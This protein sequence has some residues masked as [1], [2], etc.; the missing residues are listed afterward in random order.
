MA[1]MTSTASA[2]LWKVLSSTVVDCRSA[3]WATTRCSVR[4]ATA[5]SSFS[6]AARSS[7]P[8]RRVSPI[9]SIASTR[10]STTPA[11]SI[12]SSQRPLV[13]YRALRSARRLR[14]SAVSRSIL[15]PTFS[16][17]A[18]PS[19]R[20]INVS[21][22]ALSPALRNLINSPSAAMPA[23]TS[24]LVSSTNCVSPELSLTAAI[25]SSNAESK[26][27]L[28]LRYSSTKPASPVSAK[29]RAALSAPRN[30]GRKSEIL[31]RTVS[32]R[33]TDPVSLRDLTSRPIEA[34]LMMRRIA[35]PIPR[36]TRWEGIED[37]FC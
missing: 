13:L 7:R 6:L 17:A 3:S 9:R 4:S 36:V 5:A 2:M 8:E 14:S 28:V 34:A 12:A 27:A 10:I 29:P 21:I 24:A 20:A 1:S 37:L 26:A 16:I 32:V 18:R 30:R 35:K 22:P 25:R 19:G 33:S 11:R 15:L 23:A 31:F